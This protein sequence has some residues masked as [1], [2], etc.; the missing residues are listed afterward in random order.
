MINLLRP[1][2]CGLLLVGGLAAQGAI[3]PKRCF[4]ESVAPAFRLTSPEPYQ[5]V[6]IPFVLR[7]GAIIVKAKLGD[8]YTECQ[9]DTGALSNTWPDTLETKGADTGETGLVVNALGSVAPY[10]QMVLPHVQMAGYEAFTVPG[11]AV[12]YRTEN[13]PRADQTEPLPHL[14][15]AAFAHVVLTIDYEKRELVVRNPYYN[16]ANENRLP[17]E[18]VLPFTMTGANRRTDGV[19]AVQCEV[20]GQPAQLVLAAGGGAESLGLFLAFAQKIGVSATARV[21]VVPATAGQKPLS[22]ER[23]AAIIYPFLPE[24]NGIIGGPV[25]QNFRVTVDYLRKQPK[26]LPFPVAGR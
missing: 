22:F 6:H 9:I 8:A 21:S 7:K 20:K 24:A 1:K 5:A 3:A 19:P 2:I 17:G 15:N 23:P 13:P 14:T 16:F 26:L 4:A 18:F 10:K 11:Q 25:L 12:N